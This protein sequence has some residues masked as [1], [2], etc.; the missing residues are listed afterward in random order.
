MSYATEISRTLANTLDRFVTL[1]PHQLAGHV[2]NLDFWLLEVR[3]CINIIGGYRER[4]NA[5]T[6]AQ[7]EY[8]AAKRTVEFSYR[9]DGYCPICA[10]GRSARPP[11]PVPDRELTEALR[12]IRDAAYHFLVRCHK[13]G[14]IDVNRLREA[15]DSIGTGVDVS[16]L[17]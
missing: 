1:N 5:M 9:C 3:H 13:T 16:D 10:E 8:V 2:A 14:F 7:M 11:K 6:A 15:A 12:A 4:F 17:K